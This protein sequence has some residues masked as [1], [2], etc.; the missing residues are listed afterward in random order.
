MTYDA[1][2]KYVVLFGG[3]NG[4]RLGD[5]W[6]FNGAWTQLT[7]LT[8][9]PARYAAM[10]AYD[11]QDRYVVLFGGVGASGT[12]SDTWKFV[13]GAWSHLS[14]ANSPPALSEA[15]MVWDTADNYALLFGGLTATATASAATWSFVGGAWTHRTPL[16][17]PAARVN[18]EMGYDDHDHWV[19]LF[20]GE[21]TGGSVFSDT[22]NYTAG[23]WTQQSPATSPPGVYGGSLT[24][25]TTDGY[26]VLFG[27]LNSTNKAQGA[28][29]T[30]VNSTWTRLAPAVHPS[31]RAGVGAAFDKVLGKLV[32]F[33]GQSGSAYLGDL[34][35][36][37]SLVWLH[38][39][40]TGPGT[41]LLA[42]M[43]Y[44]E[45]DMYVLLFSG[46]L[47]HGT[48][49]TFL[50]DTRTYVHGHWTLLK[51]SASPPGRIGGMIAYDQTDGYVLLFGGRVSTLGFT[52]ANDS[53]TFLAG[54]WTQL[55]PALSPSARDASGM[56]FDA[57]D[58]Y[59]V[60]FGGYGIVP[61][62]AYLHTL[63]DTWI[64]QGGSWSLWLPHACTSCG[65]SPSG[66]YVMAMAY[67]PWDGY[68]VLFGGYNDSL[69]GPQVALSDT[70]TFLGGAWSNITGTAGTPPLPRADP[71]FVYD[72]LDGY[73]LLYGGSNQTSAPLSDTWDFVGGTWTLLSP[74]HN[75]GPDYYASSAYDPVDQAVVYLDGISL[76]GQQWLY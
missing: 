36:Y 68:I 21:T 63:N 17:N 55:L 66:R 10:F 3:W 76:A 1:A 45:A 51:T 46:A 4:S 9:P 48:S 6:T 7:P 20:G 61:G 65:A 56:A 49:V 62:A 32:V 73:V 25:D 70:W 72:S 43:V 12:L 27:G 16:A 74:A 53:W 38:P 52:L 67:D 23:K 42:E 39:P 47:V 13:K 35:T 60:L 26:L 5:T 2:D 44:D 54:K 15:G 8:S 24:N 11:V 31:A 30:Y 40:V 41:R 58:G 75:P 64:F 50:S 59:V 19:V 71:A 18:L 37:K 29:W 34:W 57:A 14:P 28:T 69:L 33:G 22:W